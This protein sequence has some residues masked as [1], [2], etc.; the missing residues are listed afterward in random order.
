MLPQIWQDMYIFPHQHEESNGT[1][2][3]TPA[4]HGGVQ[5]G[6]STR[7]LPSVLGSTRCWRSR[8]RSCMRTEALAMCP[9]GP[10]LRVVLAVLVFTLCLCVQDPRCQRNF[11]DACAFDKVIDKCIGQPCAGPSVNQQMKTVTVALVRCKEKR[12]C[13]WVSV[14][15][16]RITVHP[17]H[18]TLLIFSK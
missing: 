3:S 12:E 4:L 9:C 11:G 17:E 1:H 8:W 16:T 10:A 7:S 15:G 13:G 14:V 5:V 18:G 2:V 6:F